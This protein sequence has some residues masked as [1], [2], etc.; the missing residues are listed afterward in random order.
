[1]E[2]IV[3]MV[4]VG[5]LLFL[6]VKFRKFRIGL[7]VV[8]GLAVVGGSIAWAVTEKADHDSRNRMGPNDIELTD[9]NLRGD[10]FGYRLV[11]RAKNLSARYVLSEF[12]LRVTMRDCTVSNQCEIVGES[13]A[14]YWDDIPPGQVRAI[15]ESVSF[16]NL[17]PP[18]GKLRWDY[19]IEP[20]SIR[21]KE[22]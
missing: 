5:A 10:F 1:M 15:D 21:A 12:K 20:G 4:T 17:P 22:P 19:R 18:R 6:S 2:W 8:L 13:T 16:V 9:M 11:G 7:L 14:W 3:G